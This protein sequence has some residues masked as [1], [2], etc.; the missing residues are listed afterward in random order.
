MNE[1]EKQ[2][3]GKRKKRKLVGTGWVETLNEFVLIPQ[4]IGNVK[5]SYSNLLA[6]VLLMQTCQFNTW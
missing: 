2:G 4:V 6:M 1:V 5:L 3:K